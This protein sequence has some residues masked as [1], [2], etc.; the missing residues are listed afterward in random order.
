MRS[1]R[2]IEVPERFGVYV[3]LAGI[4]VWALRSNLL[5]LA[6]AVSL[7]ALVVGLWRNDKKRGVQERPRDSSN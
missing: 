2:N 5:L 7:V 6:Y 4:C 3:I 1:L